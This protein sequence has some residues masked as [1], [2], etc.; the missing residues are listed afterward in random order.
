MRYLC[1]L[2]MHEVV[3]RFSHL[4]E[5][6][7]ALKG[8]LNTEGLPEFLIQWVVFLDPR[9]CN[10]NE[11]QALAAAAAAAATNSSETPTS[12]ISGDGHWAQATRPSNPTQLFIGC[13]IMSHFLNLSVPLF[14]YL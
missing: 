9:I 3:R 2:P 7:Q 6:Q 12:R 11:F 1:L 8:S 4:G 10:S 14:P 13:V 5:H